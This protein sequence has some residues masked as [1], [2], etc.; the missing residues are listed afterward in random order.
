VAVH[1]I[2]AYFG[3]L[4]RRA[5]SLALRLGPPATDADLDAFARHVGFDLP[6]DL[7]HLYRLHDGQVDSGD[8]G[9]VGLVHGMQFLGLAELRRVWDDW[10]YVRS[11]WD[12]AK[13]PMDDVVVPGVVAG[14][15][16]RAGWLPVLR[17]PTRAGHLGV[18]LEPGPAG[19]Y[20][21]VINFGRDE[22]EKYAAAPS[23]AE[24]FGLL[25]DW[26]RVEGE[27]GGRPLDP[28]ELERR[29]ETHFGSSPGLLPWRLYLRATGRPV[30]LVPA[31]RPA[32]DLP[33]GEEVEVPP[34]E[35]LR[36]AVAQLF[37]QAP[38]LV[39]EAFGRR[40]DLVRV[41]CYENHR[42]YQYRTIADFDTELPWELESDLEELVA[43]VQDALTRLGMPP[44][45]DV[46]LRR[47]GDAWRPVLRT[48][49]DQGPPIE[50]WT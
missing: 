50:A 14:A 46:L 24:F 20:G 49:G 34:D 17:F 16:T 6:A 21:Q 28:E 40:S 15:Y 11:R 43:Q 35:P 32:W 48:L 9:A 31:D 18:D 23:L 41:A 3:W 2:D 42:R 45:V 10:A 25:L 26:V 44:V 37:E 13:S 27:P 19:R 47:R 33:V 7:R 8:D 38:A 1:R 5:P 4:A 30:E 22:D 36:E 12:H 29:I 39:A